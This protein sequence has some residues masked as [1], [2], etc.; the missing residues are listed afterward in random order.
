MTFVVEKMH[1]LQQLIFADG[2]RKLCS[3]GIYFSAK[4][5]GLKYIFD[6]KC[7]KNDADDD[8]DDDDDDDDELLL[9][10]G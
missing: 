3:T 8:A 1:V 2:V 10:Y 6:Q 9:W 5:S 7:P 4:M